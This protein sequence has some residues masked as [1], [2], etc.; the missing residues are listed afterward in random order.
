MEQQAKCK[1]LIAIWGNE[2]LRLG[3]A[4]EISFD[5]KKEK[6]FHISI[7]Q[8]QTR[9]ITITSDEDAIVDDLYSLFS[10]IEKLLMLLD[11]MFI[12]LSKIELSESDT[13]NLNILH[14]NETQFMEN[15]LSY[16][17]SAD[18]CNYNLDKM[19]EFSSIITADVFCRWDSLLDELDVVHQM[20]LYSLSNSGIT[21]DVKCAFLVELAEPLVEI[22]AEYVNKCPSLA[23]NVS[24]TTL[25]DC[26]DALIRK[27]GT[28]IFET[29]LSNNY[30]K[31][32]SMLKNS[33]VRIMHIK[34]KQN[35]PHFNGSE[36][37]LYSLKMSL[38]YRKIMFEILGINEIAY[39]DNLIK[40][41]SALNKWNNVLEKLLIKLA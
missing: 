26:L 32:L 20:Y 24:G 13:T 7:N 23:V 39:K 40:C 8:S 2:N 35:C 37:I 41:V 16:Y 19:L 29:E 5:I 3:K 14:F 18:F 4:Q 21:A 36:S 28:D 34:R 1:S 15:R 38:L 6:T 31:F 22:V 11:G 10:C 12:P 30:D 9:K 33:R 25:K 27:F 17:S